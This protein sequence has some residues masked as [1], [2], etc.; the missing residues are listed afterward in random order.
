MDMIL[1][2]LYTKTQRQIKASPISPP[3]TF[4][5]LI[6]TCHFSVSYSLFWQSDESIGQTERQVL[7]NKGGPSKFKFYFMGFL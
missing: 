2:V 5:S 7:P 4:L 6:E 3:H 1:V